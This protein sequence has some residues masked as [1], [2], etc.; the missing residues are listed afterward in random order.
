MQRLWHCCWTKG[1]AGGWQLRGL[2]LPPPSCC[3]LPWVVSCIVMNLADVTE[4]CWALPSLVMSIGPG[5][6]EGNSAPSARAS[7]PSWKSR[8]RSRTRLWQRSPPGTRQ[9][10]PPHAWALPAGT[11]LEPRC[12]CAS[13]SPSTPASLEPRCSLLLQLQPPPQPG[14]PGD[15]WAGVRRVPLLTNICPDVLGHG[16]WPRMWKT[17]PLPPR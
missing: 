12:P 4:G 6:A 15:V 14:P 5:R 7:S 16:E 9:G 8:S 11:R 2:S 17:P 3:H 10:A 1:C 13:P